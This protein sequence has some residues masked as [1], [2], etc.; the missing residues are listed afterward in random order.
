M[1]IC[2]RAV[3]SHLS[4]LF[5][6]VV[7]MSPETMT[8]DIV[9]AL[10]MLLGSISQNSEL[11]KDGIGALLLDLGL[12]VNAPDSAQFKLFG[13]FVDA[14]QP[15]SDRRDDQSTV[16]FHHAIH[17]VYLLIVPSVT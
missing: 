14:L 9:N 1:S 15:D 7:Q 11:Y 17:P 2:V 5:V 6:H 4:L 10:Y 3:G 12:W 8:E 16:C 13:R